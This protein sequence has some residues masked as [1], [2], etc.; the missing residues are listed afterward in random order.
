MFRLHKHLQNPIFIFS[1][2]PLFLILS[3]SFPLSHALQN[4]NAAESDGVLS[5]VKRQMEESKGGNHSMVLAAKETRRPD[6]TDDFRIYTGGWDITSQHYFASVGYS[7]IP[8]AVMAVIWFVLVGIFLLCACI[9]CCFCQRKKPYGYSRYV[10]AFSLVCLILFTMI[11]IAG[12]SVMF[13]GERRFLESVKKFTN[14]LVNRGISI[15][16]SLIRIEDLLISAKEIVLNKKYVPD[17]LKD[18]VDEADKLIDSIGRLPRITAEDFTSDIRKFITDVNSALVDIATIMLVLAFLG[19]VFSILGMKTCVC[20]FVVL[21]WIIIT[22]TFILSGIFLV[23][24]NIV[25]DTCIAMDE[26]V[27]NPKADSALEDLLP[28][29]EKEAG[30]K[31]KEAG[32]EVTTSINDLLNQ[33]VTF[34]N[35]NTAKNQSGPLVPLVC[36]PY[37]HGNSQLNCGD[38]VP[39]KNAQEEWKE[40]VCQV[41]EEGKCTTAGRLTPDMYEEM[42]KAVNISDGLYDSS[43]VIADIVDCTVV[44][45]TFRNITLDHCP[46]LM[47][48]SAWVY[49]GLVTS[50]IS[51]MF[52]LFFWL[53]FAR[54]REHRSYTKRI[55]KGYDESPLVGG[56]KL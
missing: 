50:T 35:Q 31:I 53:L 44:E 7:A 8:F 17:E 46:N 19:F 24:H 47:K 14:Y 30:E 26:W 23:F 40:Y 27:Q 1:I 38:Q 49:G 10:Y 20:M 18:E 15:W 45:E 16:E 37:E 42:S 12:S 2:P 4:D 36:D 43:F 11:S 22:L 52:C 55:N 25:S 28:C 29:A 56:K 54:E 6:P 13:T 33:V 48:Y 41:S 3:V 9:C 5:L 32:K 51:I 34:S 39:L 21:G